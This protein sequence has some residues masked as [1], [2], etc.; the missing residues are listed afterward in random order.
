[1]SKEDWK[2]TGK[3]TGSAFK[4]LGKTLVKSAKQI[5]DDVV[6]WAE[7][8]PKDPNEQNVFKDG[9]WRN[10]FKEIGGAAE[11]F[12]DTVVGTAEE[13]KTEIE[14]DITDNN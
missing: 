1:M 9:T 11:S 14:K 6:D 10:T 12:A 2:K 5:T 8:T 3:A 4:T 13:V 7:D